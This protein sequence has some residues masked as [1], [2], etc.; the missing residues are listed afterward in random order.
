LT[1]IAASDT[2]TSPLKIHGPSPNLADSI[3]L[4]LTANG[5]LILADGS[6]NGYCLAEP[7]PADNASG[8][9]GVIEVKAPAGTTVGYILL[10]S[11]SRC[12]P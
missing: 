6:A 3:S 12:G 8:W 9:V 1:L 2:S 11:N 10:Y 7:G 5:E 4:E